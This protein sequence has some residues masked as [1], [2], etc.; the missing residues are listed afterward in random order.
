MSDRPSRPQP[1]ADATQLFAEYLATRDAGKPLD[2]EALCERAGPAAQELRG[3]IQALSVLDELGE[4]LRADDDEFADGVD[5][6]EPP[7]AVPPPRVGRYENLRLLGQG[8]LSRVYVAFDPGLQR[9]VA[10]KLI[11]NDQISVDAAHDWM[12]R[13]GRSVARLQHPN[14]VRIFELDQTDDRTQTFVAMELVDGP[15]LAEVLD[16]L[17]AQKCGGSAAPTEQRIRAAA[18]RLGGIGARTALALRIARALAACH[19]ADVL[20]RDVKPGN[21]LLEADGEPKLIDFGLAHL[22][23]DGPGSQQVTQRL[24]GTP[25]YIAP[26]QVE[27]GKTGT[28]PR[29]DQFSFGVLLYELLTL[30]A[31]FERST[32]TQTLNA[33]SRALPTAPHKLDTAIPADLETICLHALE[34]EP[35]DRYPSMDA[36]ADDLEAFLDHRAI[37][38][39][40]P[41]L[42]RRCR[43]WARRHRRDIAMVGVPAAVLALAA[44]LTQWIGLRNVHAAIGGEVG[45][46]MGQLDGEQDPSSI[47]RAFAAASELERRARDADARL[48]VGLLVPPSQPRVEALMRATSHALAVQLERARAGLVRQDDPGSVDIENEILRTWQGPLS[49]DAVLCPTCPE[50]SV[51]RNRGR[52][53]LPDPPANTSLMVERMAPGNGPSSMVLVPLG[54]PDGLVLGEYRIHWIDSAGVVLANFEV[55]VESSTPRT[56][57]V[58]DPIDPEMRARFVRIPAGTLELSGWPAAPYPE[59]FALAEWLPA[60]AVRIPT[61]PRLENRAGGDPVGTSGPNAP[62]MRDLPLR[63]TLELARKSSARLPTPIEAAAIYQATARGVAG[64]P[65]LPAEFAGEHCGG[66]TQDGQGSILVHDRVSGKSPRAISVKLGGVSRHS[67]LAYRFV[68]SASPAH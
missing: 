51:D 50:N 17:R 61:A 40:G 15:N 26:E 56:A 24:I 5:D 53:D 32:R 16:E 47:Q 59:F 11:A 34:R 6:V 46:R 38:I 13:E 19:A 67:P 20:H 35:G 39:S 22:S 9:E 41:S 62:E 43:L 1:A 25:A 28:D 66:C 55:H 2:V 4:T 14:V 36:L 31:P 58:L 64:L 3:R 49:L 10:L 65:V 52:I 27:S 45:D 54:K 57:L 18:D 33:V 30:E 7:A 37:A 60:T 29:S 63:A 21:V 68:V 44:G 12:L 23:A 42:G 48:L 8:G